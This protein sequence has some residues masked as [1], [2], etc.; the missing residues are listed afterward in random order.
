M[1]EPA[2]AAGN[3]W[4]R[5][6]FVAALILLSAAP[7][8]YP[9][10]PPLVDLFGHIGRYRVQLDIGS[11]PWLSEYYTFAWAAIGNLGV[12]LLVMP[13]GN[14][15]GLEAAVKIIV[16]AIPP[17]TVGGKAHRPPADRDR[18]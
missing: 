6:W 15:L 16:L 9:K 3:W 11:S 8:I 5:R 12:D 4:E 13:F 7:L 10:V 18:A 2:A 14:L 1:V 17:M